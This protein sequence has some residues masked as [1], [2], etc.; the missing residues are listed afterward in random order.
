[1][2]KWHSTIFNCVHLFYL[3]CFTFFFPPFL[4]N[5]FPY[6]LFLNG[7][8]IFCF[9]FSM[10]SHRFLTSTLDSFVLMSNHYSL[11]LSI[12]YFTF[13]FF[14]L[15][16]KPLLFL[17]QYLLE[18]FLISLITVICTFPFFWFSVLTEVHRW[19]FFHW[20]IWRWW[21]LPVFIQKSLYHILNL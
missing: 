16:T 13:H 10:V 19:W 21:T 14:T 11:P 9:Y 18:C 5:Y 6:S 7:S 12:Y 3:P 8:Y 15:Y 17:L 4:F 1:M 20:G 2:K